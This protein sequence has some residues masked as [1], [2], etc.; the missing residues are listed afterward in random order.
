MSDEVTISTFDD[1]IKVN[2]ELASLDPM[3]RID[4]SLAE[5]KKEHLEVLT[6][7]F[8]EICTDLTLYMQ[9]FSDEENIIELNNFNGFVFNRIERAYLERICLKVATLMDPPE[10]KVKGQM[11]ENLSLQLFIKNTQST[12][13]QNIFNKLNNFYVESG[14]KE[15]RNKVLA[16]A[17]LKAMSGETEITLKFERENVDKF[18][19]EI[20][21]FIDWISDPKI[22]TDHHVVLP[23]NKDG[24]A[25]I[26]KLRE[27]NE[28]IYKK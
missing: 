12:M 11:S 3:N 5:I 18:V 7:Y 20:Q 15:W 23:R 6:R 4:F 28:F 26:E 27:H 1:F 17:D 8:L 2:P 13:L 14:I 24:H 16:H 19:S 10:S 22:S 21:E 9:I 25:F